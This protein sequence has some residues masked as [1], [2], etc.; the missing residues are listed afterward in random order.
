MGI[1]SKGNPSSSFLD[2]S[3]NTGKEAENPPHPG[4]PVVA[5]GGVKFQSSTNSYVYHFYTEPGTLE[6]TYGADIK[7]LVVGGGG[8]AGGYGGGGGGG[9]GIAWAINVPTG[10]PVNKSAYDGQSVTATITIGSGGAAGYDGN[11]S[12]FVY[13]PAADPSTPITVTALGGGAGGEGIGVSGDSG[14]A[15]GSGGGGTY[16]PDASP[17]PQPGG[18]TNQPSQNSGLPFNVEN[19]G[20]AG[21][22]NSSSSQEGS[23]GGGADHRPTIDPNGLGDPGGDGGDGRP[24]G[25]SS[26]QLSNAFLAGPIFPQMPSALQTTLG[27]DWNNSISGTAARFAGGGG[28]GKPSPNL[29]PHSGGLGGGGA[30]GAGGDNGTPG[31]NYTGGG[32]GGGGYPG[33]LGGSGGTGLV[34]IYYRP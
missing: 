23:G 11:P 6:V 9:G 18:A 32:G 3:A 1:R 10:M 30:G 12:T 5:T 14:S 7:V 2:N 31:Y 16:G 15:G 8:G 34:I 13:A 26:P 33:G 4:G 24:F 17:T 22:D 19:F 27:P 28:G 29:I 20:N 25:F 21:G